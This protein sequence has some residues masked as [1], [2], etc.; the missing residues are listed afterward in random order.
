MP[1][2]KGET[3]TTPKAGAEPRETGNARLTGFCLAVAVLALPVVG[4]A[5]YAAAREATPMWFALALLTLASSCFP[6]RI[7]SIS[8]RLW[9]T[10]SDVFVFFALYQLGVEAAVLMACLEAIGFNMRMRPSRAIRWTFNVGQI[11]LLVFVVGTLYRLA[12]R[13]MPLLHSFEIPGL[14]AAAFVAALAGLLY[15]AGGLI[16]CGYA[17]SQA[18]GKTLRVVT[19]SNLSFF[20]PTV[21]G[22]VIGMLVTILIHHLTLA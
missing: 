17:A 7:F 16:M 19:G 1:G 18:N 13:A 3:R 14:V 6:F 11:C 5:L 9:V 2:T 20:Y 12:L 8:D 21:L 22:S 4:N 10:V 15:F